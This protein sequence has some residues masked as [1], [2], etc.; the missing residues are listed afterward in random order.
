M[1]ART[2]KLFVSQ[3]KCDRLGY[4]LKI[5]SDLINIG[6]ISTHTVI[7]KDYLSLVDQLI[8]EGHKIRT[9]CGLPPTV[10]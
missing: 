7:A 8:W 3:L 9:K 10:S 2:H 1:Y 6:F 4:K 5:N